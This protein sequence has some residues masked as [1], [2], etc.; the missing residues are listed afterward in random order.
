MADW[1]GFSRSNYFKVKDKEAFLAWL[2]EI[3]D[4][5]VLHEDAHGSIA[6]MGESYGGWPTCPGEDCE[7]FDFAEELSDFLLDGEIAVLIE[8][9]AEKLR[10]ITGVAIAIDSHGNRTQLLLS[11]IYAQA[12]AVLGRRPPDATY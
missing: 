10:Y 2:S 3:G 8:A 4:V 6:I 1:W 5:S 11:D 12:E 7:P 9:G